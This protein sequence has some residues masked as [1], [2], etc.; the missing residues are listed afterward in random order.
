MAGVEGPWVL[1]HGLGRTV[2][3]DGR[4]DDQDEVVGFGNLDALA[5]VPAILW[6]EGAERLY[7][8]VSRQI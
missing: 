4:V 7:P 5:D 3:G 6:W 8:Q 2:G 1:S